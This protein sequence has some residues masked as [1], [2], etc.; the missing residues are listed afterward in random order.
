MPS[1]D[2]RLADAY[3]RQATRA[4]AAVLTATDRAWLNLPDYR[5]DDIERF[6]KTVAPIVEAGQR[7][8]AT[9]TALRLAAVVKAVTGKTAR[10]PA[11]DP[12]TV[13]TEAMRG[14]P[15]LEVYKRPG[16]TVWTALS[17]G[18]TL[19]DAITQ[20]RSRLA[21][22]TATG[23][24]LAKTHTA[25]EVMAST[26]GIVGYRRVLSGS[27]SCELCMTAAEQTYSREDLLPIHPGCN[28]DVE[29]I[30]GSEDPGPDPGASDEADVTVHEHGEIG[31][32]LA[33]AGQQFTGP[34]DL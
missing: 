6:A 27:A 13:T 4:R 1:P 30:I 8:T 9:L 19:T 34:T 14:V 21:D 26:P 15:A 10:T 28:C 23:M 3:A 7:T 18:A 17:N 22:I 2:L 29:P 33:I 20:G 32:V 31:P 11:V 16:V 24:Q 12:S 5:T 25:R